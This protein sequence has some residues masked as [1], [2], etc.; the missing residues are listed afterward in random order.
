MQSPLRLPTFLM[1][2]WLLAFCCSAA[3]SQTIAPLSPSADH[4]ETSPSDLQDTFNSADVAI[5]GHLR[6]FLRMAGISQK[7]APEEVL[8]LLAR[9]VYVQ[10]YNG[11]QGGGRQTEFL[12][13]L[14]RYVN[15]AKEL[16]ALA[17]S[18]GVIRVSNC[19]QAL[20]LLRILGYRLR[21][22]CG[23][24]N[25]S[26][27]TADA[28]RAFL[29]TDSGF[30]LLELE[31]S[32]QQ[33]R[34]FNYPFPV[35]RV[36]VLFTESDWTKVS[37]ARKRFAYDL[38]DTLLRDPALARLYWAMS[39]NDAETR[40]V[41]LHSVGLKKLLPLAAVLDF[42]GSQICIRSGRVRVPGGVSAE[43]AWKDL[44]GASPDSPAEFVPKLLSKDRGWLAAYFD[45][46]SRINQSQQQHFVEAHRLKSFYEA[47]RGADLSADAARPAFRLAPGLLLLLTRLQWDS[48]GQPLV[49]GN[50]QLWKEILSQKTNAK[51][52]HG[53][54]KRSDHLDRP[55]QLLEAMFTFSRVDT[56]SGPL[57]MY[58]LF[59]ELDSRRSPEQRLSA[60]TLRLMASR[61]D[62]F[63][64]QYLTFPEFPELNDASITHFLNAADAVDKISNHTLRGNAMGTFQANIGLWQ[65]LARQGQIPSAKLNESWQAV[66][67]PFGKFNSSAQLFDAGRSS[68]GE[69]LR[70]ATGKPNASQDEII[71][72]LAG[73]HEPGRESQRVHEEIAKG[74]RSVM[75]GQR[76]VSLDTLLALDQGL[77]DMAR[78]EQVAS[79][80]LPLA[81][82]LR[83]FEMPRP[84]FTASER[85]E[86]AAGI[87]NNRHTELQMQ[88]DLAKV[89]KPRASRAQLEDARG[90]LASFLRDTLVGLNYAYYE[91]PGAQ[92][93][94]HN[95]LFVRS[96]DFSGD[97]VMGV[98]GLWRTPQLFG[99]GS[100]AGGGAHLVGSL[101]D[102]AYVLAEAEQDFIAPENVQALIWRESVPGLITDATLPRWWGV[103][104]NELHAVTLYQRAGEELFTAAG[105]NDELRSKVMT[106]LSDRM[107]PRRA[108]WLEQALRDGR[109]EEIIP[110]MMPADTFYLTAE[111]RQRFPEE[112]SAWGPSGQQLDHLCKQY[113]EELSWERL[114][115]DFGVPHRTLAHSYTRELL[116]LKPFPAFA[117][118]SSRLLAESWDSNNLYWARLADER[119]YPPVVLNRLV[120]QLTR[121]MVEKIFA[122]DFEDWPALLRAM[123]EAGEEFRQGKIGIF[124]ATNIATKQ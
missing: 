32:L 54:G 108:L 8:P 35:T 90:Q 83:E 34:D 117:G 84:I 102:L 119:G 112:T 62:Q 43:S 20:P 110:E 14:G 95:P 72:L 65:I 21:Q 4:R 10:G 118:Y 18:G 28:E 39:R 121:R 91:P 41:L 68:L 64:D 22:D 107:V 100:P 105:S 67:K 7:A 15:Q 99:E 80:L 6:S 78:G 1:A 63:S 87:Y 59:S 45:S 104:R 81:G 120:P 82:E 58:L 5:A 52:I 9:N 3:D 123:N 61:Y 76:L 30:P 88:T 60:D 42:Y 124:P 89:L 40:V 38:V 116:N 122:T 71:E 93:L 26:L 33:G 109:A 96:H 94:H 101:A 75:D 56:D 49:P 36:P 77:A 113:P 106:I 29:T 17:G 70:A 79:S 12:I 92:V 98:E 27:V 11:W 97:T 13:L 55:E 74:I 57:Q 85:T 47:F 31:E 37:K 115:R 44:V 19:E 86:W 16:A 53:W 50:L 48:D 66:I 73:P 69:I 111:F 2:V 114:S 24:R 103:S 51:A 25:A 46:L 23:Q